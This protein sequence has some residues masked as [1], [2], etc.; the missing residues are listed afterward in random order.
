[1]I[2]ILPV[3]IFLTC[4]TNKLST[5]DRPKPCCKLFNEDSVPEADSIGLSCSLCAFC[6]KCIRSVLVL[7]FVG[8]VVIQT[9]SISQN[10]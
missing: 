6:F 3:T 1:M 9:Q 8:A 4:L 10:P 5:G 7:V 2:G